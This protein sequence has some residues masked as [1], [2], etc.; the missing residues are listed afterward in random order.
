[1]EYVCLTLSSYYIPTCTTS[2]VSG[3]LGGGAIS[4]IVIVLFLVLATVAIGTVVLLFLYYK[5][6]PT[7]VSGITRSSGNTHWSVQQLYFDLVIC[8]MCT[9]NTYTTTP[10]SIHYEF[11]PTYHYE[12]S[13]TSTQQENGNKNESNAAA[14][15]SA[16][17]EVTASLNYTVPF[18]ENEVRQYLNCTH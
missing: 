4:A 12:F 8:Y 6:K 1:M 7:A 5:R 18:I 2:P 17:C 9:G 11:S 13:P 10:A 3:G 14:S 16:G 15:A